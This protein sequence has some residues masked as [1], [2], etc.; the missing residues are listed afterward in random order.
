MS[1]VL[2]DAARATLDDALTELRK[3][4]DGLTPEQLNRRLAGDRSNPLAVIATHALE[5]TRSWLSLATGVTLPPRDRPAEFRAVADAGFQGWVDERMALC[6]SVLADVETID[7]AREG[8]A[9]WRTTHADEPV[10]AAW[11]LLHAVGHLEEHVGHAHVM[12]DLLETEAAQ[13]AINP[14]S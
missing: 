13:R 4:V 1:V 2:L 7:P 12:R 10:T 8:T 9:P 3:A 5:S 6:R 11:A 14:P